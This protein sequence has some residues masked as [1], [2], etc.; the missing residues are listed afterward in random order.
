M[1]CGIKKALHKRA[2]RV[3]FHC[4]IFMWRSCFSFT[5]AFIQL[6]FNLTSL[7]IPMSIY[8]RS[9][10]EVGRREAWGKWRYSLDSSWNRSRTGYYRWLCHT[11]TVFYDVCH[12]WRL[13]TGVAFWGVAG[14]GAGRVGR[15]QVRGVGNGDKGEGV[16]EVGSGREGGCGG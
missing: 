15:G 1:R 12:W 2:Q 13:G 3:L 8:G 6:L 5:H 16:R 10:S 11:D 9:F 14:G 4:I 7:F